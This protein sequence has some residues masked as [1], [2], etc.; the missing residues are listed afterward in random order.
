M[1]ERERREQGER[2]AVV[3]QL[4]ISFSTQFYVVQV[5]FEIR[6]RPRVRRLQG[7]LPEETFTRGKD[8]IQNNEQQSANRSS[9]AQKLSPLRV[10]VESEQES[11]QHGFERWILRW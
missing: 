7:L 6:V 3:V 8:D 10:G 2:L 4:F 9:R 1:E 11:S 5:S